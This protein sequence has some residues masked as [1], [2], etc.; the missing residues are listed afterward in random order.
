MHTL[1]G[2]EGR[3]P[4]APD[5][6]RTKDKEA[7]ETAFKEGKGKQEVH[8]T[9]EEDSEAPREGKKSKERFSG[10]CLRKCVN[11]GSVSESV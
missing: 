4:Q 7:P 11:F 10:E 3:K 8:D 9:C 2:T 5:K 6:D 1:Y